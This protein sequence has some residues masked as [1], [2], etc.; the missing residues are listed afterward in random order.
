MIRRLVLLAA[1]LL[2]AL[3]MTLPAA[4]AAAPARAT[5]PPTIV[6]VA[7]GHHAGFDRVTFTFANGALPAERSWA[8]VPQLIADPSGKTIPI[9]G[10]KI[11]RVRFFSAATDVTATQTP[12]LPEVKQL[13]FAGSFEGVVSYGIGVAVAR[14]PTAHVL[15]GPLPGQ[16]RWYLDI[17]TTATRAATQAAQQRQIGETTLSNFKVV[18]TATRIGTGYQ[19]TVTAAGYQNVAG[20]WALI[21]RQQIGDT[22]Q[23]FWYS[24][25]V[26]GLTVTQL[27]PLPSSAE[28]SDTLTVS[29]LMTP[30]LGCHPDLTA[31]WPVPVTTSAAQPAAS[32][33]GHV[34]LKA[35]GGTIALATTGQ[36]GS[37]VYAGRYRAS[38]K[39]EDWGADHVPGG[40][41]GLFWAPGHQTD[42]YVSAAA[43]AVRLWPEGPGT[44]NPP[45]TLFRPASGTYA[46]LAT[47]TANGSLRYLTYLG[48]GGKVA[49]RP[50]QGPHGTASA[51]QL[52]WVQGA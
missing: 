6:K 3:A 29:L 48:S 15:A 17:P 49:L 9:I 1:A 16:W 41:F 44:H 35:G 8:Y 30:A 10:P 42:D 19:A 39:A 22:G 2:T 36:A 43:S 51:N 7:T 4:L 18:L 21:S 46:P 52:W 14:T 32:G 34:I 47:A 26:C 5:A 11:I 23:W 24:T 50:L 38:N 20:H 33:Y 27:K 25:E 37:L 12:L 13:K 45:A 28:T 40:R 31:T